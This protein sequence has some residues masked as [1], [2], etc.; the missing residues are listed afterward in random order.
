MPLPNWNAKSSNMT[1]TIR[2]I[3]GVRTTASCP[4]EFVGMG[5]RT[6]SIASHEEDGMSYTFQSVNGTEVTVEARS[7]ADARHKAMVKLW[8]W[9]NHLWPCD[10]YHGHGLVLVK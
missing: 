8:G 2:R 9:P 5:N 6:S 3:R 4:R 7:E 10:K 1:D